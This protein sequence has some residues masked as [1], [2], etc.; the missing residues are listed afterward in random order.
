MKFNIGSHTW[1]Y[2]N[3]NVHRGKTRSFS[4]MLH[5]CQNY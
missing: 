5:T 4:F 3:S 2:T 1:L